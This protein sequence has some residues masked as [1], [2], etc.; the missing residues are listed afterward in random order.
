M[1]C[2]ENRSL[3]KEGRR[4]QEGSKKEVRRKLNDGFWLAG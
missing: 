1:G 4:K 3:G 2:K